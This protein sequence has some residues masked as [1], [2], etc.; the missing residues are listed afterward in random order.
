[1]ATKCV[2]GRTHDYVPDPPDPSADRIRTACC[3]YC[4]DVL[5]VTN[6]PS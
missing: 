2:P 5:M 4:G 3:K 1:M 6:P